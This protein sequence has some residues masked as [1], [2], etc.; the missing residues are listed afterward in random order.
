[1][2]VKARESFKTCLTFATPFGL[3]KK[4]LS[5]LRWE[6]I[7]ANPWEATR[8]NLNLNKFVPSG[9]KRCAFV[10]LEYT[11]GGNGK[12]KDTHTHTNTYARVLQVEKRKTLTRS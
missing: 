4:N 11:S 7:S 1:M 10:Y 12:L 8:E 6:R 5:N 3:I 2:V 9:V